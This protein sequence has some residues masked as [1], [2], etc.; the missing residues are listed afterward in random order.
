MQF[1][2]KRRQQFLNENHYKEVLPI[3]E[4]SI[5]Y[6]SSNPYGSGR[7][8]G[9]RD[10]LGRVTAAHERFQLFL[11][12]YTA[13]E[14]IEPLRAE[15]EEVIAAYE[16]YGEYLWQYT[17]DRNEVVFKFYDL[18]EYCQLMQLIGLCF[19]LHRRD[20]LP[21]I[22]S[23]QDGE[24]EANVGADWLLEEFL[25]YAPLVRY[26]TESVAAT[27]PY[28]ALIDAMSSEDNDAALK[29]IDRY[30]KHW[31]KDLAG[32]GWHDSHKEDGSGYYGYWSFE[33]GAAVVLLGI[34]DDSSL[35][36]Y[37]YYPKDLVA[38]ARA[39][40]HREQVT[41]TS[42]TGLRCPGGQ[43]CPKSGWWH[44]PAAKDSRRYFNQGDTMP[45][46]EGSVYGDTYWLWDANQETPKL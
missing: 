8:E 9:E 15:L 42:G 35:H 11:M 39:N 16:R 46:I 1:Q 33:A 10:M 40:K 27:R 24:G 7:D 5:S 30:L 37:L 21:R 26:E 41:P 20:L 31:Y 14:P 28:E 25:S 12:R 4:E 34:D 17:R 19:L 23:M 6:F 45:N 3:L 13:G 44:T 22:A 2:E 29:D 32:T 38:W 18:D 43:P 36:K